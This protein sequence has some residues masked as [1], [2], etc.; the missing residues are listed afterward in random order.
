MFALQKFHKMIHGRKF[1][2]HTD[3]KPLIVIFG[4]KKGIPLYTA[5]RLQRWDI[6]A[7]AYDFTI[8]YRLTS[9]FGQ[10]DALSRLIALYPKDGETVIAAVE[11]DVQQVLS[12]SIWAL[13]VTAKIISEET[14]EDQNLKHV[15]EFLKS[16]WPYQPIHA[17]VRK[18][19]DRRNSLFIA[20]GCLMYGDRVV[21]PATLQRRVLRQLREGHPGIAR[22]KATA[23][24]H[25][26]SSN[27]D[28]GIED[29]VRTCQRCAQMA[30]SPTKTEPCPWPKT[31][32]PWTRIH[33][34]YAGPFLGH[35]FFVIFDSYSK[36]PEII[37]TNRITATVTVR[38]LREALARFV[39]PEMFVTD[40]GTLFNSVEFPDLC[41]ANG[42][43]QV[44]SPFH[45]QS[46]GQAER[47]V[48]TLKRSLG[49]GKVR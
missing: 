32:R 11:V 24:S 35:Y 5:S 4:A 36:W 1:T 15:I 22:M 3:P 2:L 41:E 37:M 45:P 42:I 16:S 43:Q 17:D 30:K 10:A 38:V 34:D 18:F 9:S 31:T 47:F 40:N 6:T 12:H 13:P 39:M 33:I 7:L 26:Y 49:R 21:I 29:V 27:V 44:K 20:N 28:V 23:R 19:F 25:V 46:N 14:F 48:D 8:E